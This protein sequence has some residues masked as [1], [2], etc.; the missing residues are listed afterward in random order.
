MQHNLLERYPGAR[1]RVY[2]IWTDKR[3][4][5]SR[6]RWDAAGLVDRRVTHLWDAPDLSGNWLVEHAPDYHAGDW[7]A[8]ALFGPEAR[9]DQTLPSPLSSGST[10]IGS[11]DDLARAIAPLV[12]GAGVG[13]RPASPAHLPDGGMFW[14]KRNT[15]PGSWRSLTC[16]RRA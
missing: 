9:W 16:W 12:G 7:D 11:S 10:V 2:A 8:Y 5:D 14:L 13:R 4:F 6:D 1:L 15:L 3:F